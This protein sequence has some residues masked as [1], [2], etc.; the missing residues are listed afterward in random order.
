LGSV[1]HLHVPNE[2]QRVGSATSA[3]VLTLS[4]IIGELR[5]TKFTA[6]KKQLALVAASKMRSTASSC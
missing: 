2:L 5:R 1:Y 3:Y 4:F 6:A